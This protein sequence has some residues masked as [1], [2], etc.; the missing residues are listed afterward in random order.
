MISEL[1]K[2][3]RSQHTQIRATTKGR[4]DSAAVHHHDWFKTGCAA[5]VISAMGPPS[6]GSSQLQCSLAKI[7]QWDRKMQ[8]LPITSL[9]QISSVQSGDF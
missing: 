3:T 2:A 5:L 7:T 1:A 6:T 4:A 8:A 9:P